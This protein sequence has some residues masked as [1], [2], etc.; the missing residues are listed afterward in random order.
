VR[1]LVTGAGGRLGRELLTAFAGHEV[2][3]LSREEL[4]VGSEPAVAAAVAELA[5]ALVVNTAAATDVDGCERDPEGAH[6]VNAL[7][8]WWLAR[9]CARTGAEL[10]HVSTDAVF[11]GWTP[12]DVSGAPRPFT[13]FDPAAPISV[14]GRSKDAGE[15]L[16]RRTLPAHHIVRIAW[17]LDREGRDFVG[18]ILRVARERGRVEVVRDQVGSP[19]WVG[20]AATAIAEVA[21][22]GRHGTVHRAGRGGVSRVDLAVAA[23][24]LAGVDAEV[25][26]IDGSARSDPAPRAPWTVL[27]DRHA[28]AG[29]L[30]E[31][32]G[33]REQLRRALEARG[34]LA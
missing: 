10:L 7:G 19:T 3:G 24:D 28:V 18:A 5:P 6:R 23:I 20:D 30:R 4:D 21:R 14:Y 34:D 12:T 31:M 2:T 17:V 9:A 33:W 27:D 22:S 1:I 26:P 15:Q 11:G 32:A 13:E 8:P 29:G 25:V 16:I